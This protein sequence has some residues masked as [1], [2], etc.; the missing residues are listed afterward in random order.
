MMV[1][2]EARDLFDVHARIRQIDGIGGLLF[3]RPLSLIFVLEPCLKRRYQCVP[4]HEPG[5][6]LPGPVDDLAMGQRSPVIEH[7]AD[8]DDRGASVCECFTLA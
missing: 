7:K 3:A 8:D 4:G 5:A 2:A 6:Y 1:R